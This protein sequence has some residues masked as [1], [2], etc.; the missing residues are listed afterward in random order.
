LIPTSRYL[1]T[2]FLHKEGFVRCKAKFMP[3]TYRPPQEVP[4]NESP[5]ILT[6]ARGLHHFHPGTLT[7]RVEGLN[8]LSKEE[9]V[10]ISHQDTE[11]LGSS[12][13]ELVKVL[14]R[15][16]EAV[17]RVDV[18]E[19]MPPGV[20]SMTFC[21]AESQINKLTNHALNIVGKIPEFKICAVRIEKM[22][23]VASV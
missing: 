10:E 11:K 20:I 14:S 8:R 23:E 19:A 15:R 17:A 16:S 7:S 12:A 13:N 5:L 22:L 2:P 3:R 18:N 6:T 4:D 9:E 21:F 1:G